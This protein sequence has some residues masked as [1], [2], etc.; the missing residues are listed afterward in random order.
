MSGSGARRIIFG[1]SG[2]S[3]EVLHYPDSRRTVPE[4]VTMGV[5][6]RWICLVCV[7]GK[8][9][10]SDDYYMSTGVLIGLAMC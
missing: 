2:F 1:S 3:E 7:R 9:T 5:P 10:T 6:Y 8:D 4:Q